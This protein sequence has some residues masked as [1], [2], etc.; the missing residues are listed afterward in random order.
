MKRRWKVPVYMVQA[1]EDESQES[2]GRLAD[3]RLSYE[4][5]FGDIRK[6]LV[7]RT[8]I[9]QIPPSFGHMTDV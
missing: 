4:C 9:R 2:S 5:M 7:R 8:E 1:V 6:D 3:L